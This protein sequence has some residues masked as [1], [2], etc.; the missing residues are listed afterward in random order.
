MYPLLNRSSQLGGN[1]AL[2]LFSDD[3]L[4]MDW[5]QY[6]GLFGFCIEDARE[7][8]NNIEVEHWQIT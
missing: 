3:K 2:L 7:S 4:L 5:A 6:R 8:H 1:S